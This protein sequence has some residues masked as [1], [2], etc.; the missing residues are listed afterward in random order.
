MGNKDV[1]IYFY[2]WKGLK[3]EMYCRLISYIVYSLRDRFNL[4]ILFF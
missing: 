2:G 1:W 4:E 3:F